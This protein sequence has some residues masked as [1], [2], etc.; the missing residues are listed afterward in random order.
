VEKSVKIA[1]IVIA[2]RIGGQF[3]IISNFYGAGF[4]QSLTAIP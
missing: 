3:F 2:R 4:F 1:Y